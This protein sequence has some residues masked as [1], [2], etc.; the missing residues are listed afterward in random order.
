MSVLRVSRPLA[1]Y[2]S[3]TMTNRFGVELHPDR[4][5]WAAAESVSEEVIAAVLLLHDRSVDEIAP[6]LSPTEL[7]KVIVLVGRNPRL[8]PPGIMDALEQQRSFPA[9]TPAESCPHAAVK[10]QT[11]G[12]HSRGRLATPFKSDADRM[13]QAH[14]RRLAMLRAHIPRSAPEPER[15]VGAPARGGECQPVRRTRAA[16]S[17]RGER[18][19]SDRAD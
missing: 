5:R 12:A 7:E 4:L 3:G 13:Q 16:K 18:R 6:K 17:G 11:T 2:Y 15:I 14:E 19:V 1:E 9:S 10:E 8:Y